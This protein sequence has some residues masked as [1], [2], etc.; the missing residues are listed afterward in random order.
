MHRLDIDGLRALAVLPVILFH[1]GMVNIAPGGFIGVDVF[2]VISG[3]LITGIIDREVTSG[4]YRLANFYERRIRRI[5]PALFAMFA[6]CMVCAF[7]LNFPSEARDIGKSILASIGFVSN[8][9]FYYSSSYFDQKMESNPVLHT[10]SLSVEE[11]FYIVFPLLLLFLNRFAHNMRLLAL[12]VIFVVSLIGSMYAV[13]HD[14]SGAFYLVQYRA[15]EL[16]IGSLLALRV[17]PQLNSK[18]V[19][20]LLGCGGIVAIIASVFLLDKTSSFPG[21]NALAPCLGAAA[22]IYSGNAFATAAAR[23]LG[24]WP[25]RFIGKISYSLYLWHWP[26]FV[27][28]KATGEPD[29]TIK[30]LLIGLCFVVSIVSWKFI[31]SPFR[32][33]N[34]RTPASR[35]VQVGAAGMG[36][37]AAVTLM[38]APANAAFWHY[39]QRT[40]AVLAFTDYDTTETMRSGRCFLTSGSNDA[41]MYKRDECLAISTRQQNVLVIGDSHAAHLWPGLQLTRPDINFLQATASGCKPTIPTSGEQRCTAIIDYVFGEFLPKHHLDAIILSGRW[42]KEDINSVVATADTLRQFATL[43]IISGP[44]V[45]YDNSLPK[46]LARGVQSGDE[47]QLAIQHRKHEQAQVDQLLTQALA[48]GH[49]NVS[50]FSPYQTLCTPDCRVWAQQDVPMQ[51]DYGHLTLEGSKLVAAQLSVLLPRT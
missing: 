18:M 11:Q 32:R 42:T 8:I 31:E 34:S 21:L 48:V 13:R 4:T 36:L 17:V 24:C 22:I 29:R 3:Y 38:V 12:S 27:F 15:W 19:A 45:E 33:R 37:T 14:P 35:V 50:Y 41:A 26:I 25:L 51:F 39:T 49:P 23:F 5:F 46:I 44:I 1:Y 30:L 43:I 40:E 10:W 9:L 16:L 6:M 28:Y 20:E 47:A 2:F 7:W